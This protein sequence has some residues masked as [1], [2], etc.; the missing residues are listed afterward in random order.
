MRGKATIEWELDWP[1]PLTQTEKEEWLD[2]YLVV[3]VET[4]SAV[5]GSATPVSVQSLRAVLGTSIDVDPGDPQGYSSTKRRELTLVPIELSSH[6]SDYYNR[7]IDNI[8]AAWPDE[9]LN[10]Y[11]TGI[12]PEMMAANPSLVTWS[13]DGAALTP[14]P[15]MGEVDLTWSSTG[16][17]EVTVTVAGNTLTA[18]VDVPDVGYIPFLVAVFSQPVAA[19]ALDEGRYKAEAWAAQFHSKDEGEEGNAAQHSYW[20][21]FAA[22]DML[23]TQA[24]TLYITTAYEYQARAA[25]H[26]AF[27]SSMDLHNNLV[28]VGVNHTNFLGFP[29]QEAIKNELRGLLRSGEMRVIAWKGNLMLVKS[30]TRKKFF[31]TWW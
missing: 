12:T 17:K 31:P 10:L 9:P 16:L 19:T 30:V 5:P 29:A 21:A 24:A 3:M 25:G 22:S 23:V 11:V 6:G 13:T 4:D 26:S 2:R 14:A 15:H 18:M 7:R 28:G 1:E 20:N 8:A 27:D